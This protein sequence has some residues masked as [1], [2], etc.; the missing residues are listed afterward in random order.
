MIK[1]ISVCLYL[2]LVSILYANFEVAPQIQ[3]I[4]L[5]RPSTQKIYL[6]NPT[7]KL[8]KLKIYSERPKDQKNKGFYMGD[9]IIVYPKIVYLKPK[10]KKILRMAARAPK[11][12]ENGEYRSYLAIE[13][14]PL[15]VYD[16]T[17]EN[18]TEKS[19]EVKIL[20][21]IVSTIYGY[22]GKLNYDGEF[23]G[24]KIVEDGKKIQLISNIINSGTTALDTFYR[25]TYYENNKKLK[26]EDLFLGKIMRENKKN[27]FKQLKKIPKNAN[28]MKLELYYWVNRDREEEIEDLEEFKLGEKIIPIEII[29]MK[30]YKK[31]LDEK[32][33]KE[34][35]EVKNKGE[36]IK[37]EK[38]S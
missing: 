37:E 7:D 26:T 23:G 4:D 21:K 35:I 16:N 9:W 1:K 32:N 18:I 38:E 13:E 36:K 24:F 29:S 33:K 22:K 19:V 10:S 20:Y 15:Q 12:I 2:W 6:R 8:K 27:F 30:E 34:K 25:I 11:D 14:I 5:D 28:K 3:K 17:E 31:G